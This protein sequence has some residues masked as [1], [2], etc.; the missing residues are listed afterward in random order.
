MKMRTTMELQLSFRGDSAETA[1]L[2]NG[3]ADPTPSR[4]PIR[5]LRGRGTDG[6][7]PARER[8]PLARRRRVQLWF[9]PEGLDNA[10]ALTR[11]EVRQRIDVTL[12]RIR[13]PP[14]A[15]TNNPNGIWDTDDLP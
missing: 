12:E 10:H 5:H 3:R 4:S 8:G 13:V 7:P 9:T 6:V 15:T 11:D 2:R 1:A 14:A